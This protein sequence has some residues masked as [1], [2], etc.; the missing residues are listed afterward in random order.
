MSIL[1]IGNGDSTLIKTQEGLVVLIDTG[2]DASITSRM[3]GILGR[4]IS[5]ID[6]LVLTHSHADHIGGATYVLGEYDV[7]CIV[8]RTEDKNNSLMEETLRNRLIEQSIEV[9]F[10]FAN[11]T[12]AA[13]SECMAVL[14]ALNELDLFYYGNAYTA[15]QVKNN[16]NLESLFVLYS[17]GNFNYW[18]MS[19]NEYSIQ[20]KIYNSVSKMNPG[21]SFNVLKVPHQGSEDSLHKQLIHFINPQVAIISVGING[22]GH[23]H[24]SVVNFYMKSVPLLLNT[25]LDSDILI[26]KNKSDIVIQKHCYNNIFWCTIS[27]Y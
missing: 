22:Y 7:R 27:S 19:D 5:T 15:N 13:G 16:Q 24:K 17:A 21:Q 6:L 8:Y 23:P 14:D 26:R 10:P 4:N 2:P 11:D 20:E 18:H 25:R 1:N 9:H 12:S 3:A